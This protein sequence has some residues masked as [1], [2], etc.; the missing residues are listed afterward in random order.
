[1]SL[2]DFDS[3][4][5]FTGGSSLVCPQTGWWSI[6]ASIRT[7]VPGGNASTMH[8]V[9]NRIL[10]GNSEVASHS[11]NLP[12]GSANPHRVNLTYEGPWQSGD[13]AILQGQQYSPVSSASVSS[14]MLISCAYLRETV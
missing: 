6:T 13:M 9:S 5:M 12:L 2:A 8:I 10:L 3:D 11:S 7:D 4:G 14:T 1:M